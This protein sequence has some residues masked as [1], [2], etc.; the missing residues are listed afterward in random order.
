MYEFKSTET[1]Y[2][3]AWPALVMV[4]FWALGAGM[5]RWLNAAGPTRAW[6]WDTLTGAADLVPAPLLAPIPG[7]TSPGRP[8]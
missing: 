1:R 5:L 6:R 7:R 2:R 3:T 8:S 4:L